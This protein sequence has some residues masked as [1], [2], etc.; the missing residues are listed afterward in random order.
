MLSYV[1]QVYEQPVSYFRGHFFPEAKD[2]N[3]FQ[4]QYFSTVELFNELD[5][6]YSK[7]LAL[8]LLPYKTLSSLGTASK[9]TFFKIL[10][11]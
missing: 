4:L 9:N 6:I 1:A 5:Q 8:V 11:S 7:T 10:E 2:G 3:W